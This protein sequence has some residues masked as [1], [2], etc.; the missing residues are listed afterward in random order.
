MNIFTFLKARISILDVVSQYATLKKAGGYWKGRCPFHHEKT[1]SFTVSPHREIF[2]CFGCHSGGDVIAFI[3]KAEQIS[4]IEAAKMLADRYNLELPQDI[5]F[6]ESDQEIER[7]NRYHDLCKVVSLWCHEQL[8]ASH[9]VLTY[10]K[11]RGIT[12]QSIRT[13]LIGFF[14]GGLHGT[15][16]CLQ[17]GQKEHFLP[18]DFV[19]SHILSE[20]KTVLYSPFEDRII[21][22]I[23]DNL[24]RFCGFGGRTY[25]STDTRA[26][27]YNSKETDHFAKGSLLFGLDAA[28][29]AIQQT[30]NVILVEGYMDCIAMHQ[31][32][33]ANTVATLGTAC[34]SAHLKLLARY[35][36]RLLV[37]YD[38][39]D[40]GRQAALRM[41][42]LCW[43][44]GIELRVVRMPNGQ[45]P[46]SLLH[47]KGDMTSL[48]E[49]AQDIFL[50]F[51]E[52]LGANF[53]RKSLS[54][55]V[56]LARRII[57]VIA[58]IDDPLKQDLLLQ[59]AAD[60]LRI[61]FDALRGELARVHAKQTA[62]AAQEG[63]D[64]QPSN[65]DVKE[66]TAPA[67]EKRIL[68]AILNNIQLFNNGNEKYLL[69]YM[70]GPFRAIL[71]R[72][73]ELQASGRG[74]DFAHF[75]ETL[76]SQQ[77]QYVSKLLLEHDET[78]DMQ[79]F[80]RLLLQLQKRQWKIIV[81]TITAQLD[82]AK[83]NQDEEKVQEILRDFSELKQRIILN[84]CS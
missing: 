73:H 52:S 60:H 80:D 62:P 18:R 11:Q 30:G 42:E 76:N 58:T 54:E 57:D 83:R 69:N 63:T 32:G 72:I 29:K 45:D 17:A 21:F 38:G 78:V 81:R 46:A 1:G 41:T 56:Q 39:D 84:A 53:A 61:P 8:L 70:P 49:Q 43:Q 7:K 64:I 20:G 10:L 35:A 16:A 51:I 9:T 6:G 82:D 2:Y 12:E 59:Q 71:K 37:A 36:Q 66:Q 28:K 4:P 3:A 5:S 74:F 19:E 34:T 68:C 33:F 26:K 31:H 24:G 47:E 44:V 27:Y 14:P 25:K 65:D 79:A 48:L 77:Q 40:A 50:F 75:F 23:R 67:L 13:F 22:P 15:K 55:K